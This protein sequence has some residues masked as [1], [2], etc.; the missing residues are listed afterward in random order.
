MTDKNVQDVE[1]DDND[2]V[3]AHDPKNAEQQSV[4]SVK[5]AEKAG[6]TA[7][8]RKGDKSNSEPMPKSKAG[9][10][11]AGYEYMSSLKTEELAVLWMK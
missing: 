4:D 7:K 11:N 2:V 6:P 9:M 3:E 5:A 1:L 10:I 8:S